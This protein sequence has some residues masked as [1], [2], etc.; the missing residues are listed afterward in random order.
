MKT[1]IRPTSFED[2][3]THG[4][5]SAEDYPNRTHCPCVGVAPWADRV[6]CALTGCGYCA[7]QVKLKKSKRR[8]ADSR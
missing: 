7:I 6:N 5:E 8:E 1:V 2:H 4:R 3:A